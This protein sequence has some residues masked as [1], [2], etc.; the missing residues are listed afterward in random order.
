MRQKDIS[1]PDQAA[2]KLHAANSSAAAAIV[3]FSGLATIERS[4]CKARQVAPNQ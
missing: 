1:R 4:D 3:N 2:T